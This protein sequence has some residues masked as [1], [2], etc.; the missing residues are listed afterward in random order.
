MQ[1]AF[2]WIGKLVD[3]FAQFFPRWIILDMTMGGVK[4]VGGAKAVALGPGIHWYW[5]ARTSLQTY[6][7]A[8]QTDN[9]PTQTLVTSDDKTIAISAMVVYEVEDIEKLL[10]HTYSAEKTI[11]DLCLSAIRR[12]C[13]KMTWDDL[14]TE[15]RRGT[16][17]TKLKNA[18]K[19]ELENYGIRVLGAVLT[20]L[21]PCRVLRL[22]QS[23]A[24]D[25]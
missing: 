2:E 3:W 7:I 12:V 1:G 14:K 13:C 21:A 10:A 11:Q 4:F 5:P 17:D 22:V 24:S 9:L 20:D 23:T 25:T 18:A 16:L 19:W 15:D 6:P 8:R